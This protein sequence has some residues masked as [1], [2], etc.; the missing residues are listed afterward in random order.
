MSSNSPC[1]C[2]PSREYRFDELSPYNPYMNYGKS[3]ME[4]EIIAKKIY[5]E[6]LLDL[7]IIRSPWFYGPYQPADKNYSL[8]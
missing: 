1:G 5:K 7:S 3:K 4:M 8:K 2:N 6:G